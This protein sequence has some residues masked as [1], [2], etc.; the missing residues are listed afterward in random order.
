MSGRSKN[1]EWITHPADRP[2]AARALAAPFL[3]F[4][5]FA[6]DS[7]AG[8]EIVYAVVTFMLIGKTITSGRVRTGPSFLRFTGRSRTK[9]RT[10]TSNFSAG[11]GCCCLTISIV[12][13]PTV[14]NEGR[15]AGQSFA[16]SALRVL[17]TAG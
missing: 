6:V 8:Y 5:P 10:G 3:L 11:P 2:N 16:S 13:S 4:A 1:G 15:H 14:C 7:F 12:R 17:Q 9:F